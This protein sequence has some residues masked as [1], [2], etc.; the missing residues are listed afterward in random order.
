[1]NQLQRLMVDFQMSGY[2]A[3][4]NAVTACPSDFGMND[5]EGCECESV[6]RPCVECW[7]QEIGEATDDRQ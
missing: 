7:L 3:L 4:V 2:E 1:M 6:D 5:I